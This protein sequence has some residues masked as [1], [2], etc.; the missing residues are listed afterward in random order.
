MGYRSRKMWK[1]LEFFQEEE[2]K[3]KNMGGF[4]EELAGASP[5]REEQ[6]LRKEAGSNESLEV[7]ESLDEGIVI[8]STWTIRRR[9]TV[10]S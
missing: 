7:H 9:H 6:G 10:E 1:Q 8:V 4:K 3:S 2:M 5:A